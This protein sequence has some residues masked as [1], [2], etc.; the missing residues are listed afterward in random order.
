MAKGRSKVSIIIP[1]YNAEKTLERCLA[2]IRGQ[3]YDCFEAIVVNDGSTDGTAEI[4]KRFAAEDRRFIFISREMNLGVSRTR[5]EGI[6]RARGK[7]LQF[8][9][10]DDY[11][12][13]CATEKMVRA[14]EESGCEMAISDF[15]R[16]VGRKILIKGDIREGGLI[17]RNEYA[18]CM[19]DAPAN[20]YYGVLWNK[21]YLRRIVKE[22]SVRFSAELDWCEDLRF[23]LEYL[24]YVKN[25][26]V[27]ASPTYYYM[28]RKGSLSSAQSARDNAKVKR[29]LFGYYKELYQAAELYD[30]NRLKIQRYYFDFARDRTKA[31]RKVPAQTVPRRLRRSGPDVP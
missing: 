9:D 4:A 23:N 14:C 1:A 25:V 16:I 15:Y 29:I 21:L 20:F 2:S 11:L 19:M 24:L 17:S 28:R 31:V 13:P 18:G 26:C 27:I 12:D 6:Q 10:S 7:Y 5:N 22:M 30:E 8:V 3:T